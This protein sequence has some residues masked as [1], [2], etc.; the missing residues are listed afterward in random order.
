MIGRWLRRRRRARELEHERFLSRRRYVGEDVTVFGEQ[1]SQLHV[2][3][4]TDALGEDARDYYRYALESY[5]RAKAGLATAED[6]A[7]L[8]AVTTSLVDGRHQRACVLAAA[9]GEPMPAKLAECFFNP[10][11][12]PSN[13]EVAWAPPGGVERMVPVCGA[14]ARRIAHGQAP[15]MRLVR[16]GDRYVPMVV[17]EEEESVF[18]ID[19]DGRAIRDARRDARATAALWGISDPV[20]DAGTGFSGL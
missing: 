3:T 5:E 16:V 2:D 15:K 14:D 17:A 10:Q 20:K 8:E 6:E 4:L 9:A 11:H 13:A 1:L 12:G 7:A 19:R 18:R